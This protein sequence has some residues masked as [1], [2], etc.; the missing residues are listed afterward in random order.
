MIHV[1]HSE[2]HSFRLSLGS[3]SQRSV[4]SW[5]RGPLGLG[6]SEQKLQVDV[7]HPQ[8]EKHGATPHP[9]GLAGRALDQRG[10]LLRLISSRV[11]LSGPV[12]FALSSFRVAWEHHLFLLPYFSLLDYKCLSYACL[13]IVFWKPVTSPLT[14]S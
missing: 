4:C 13:T 14:G 1:S 10:L 5:E 2:Y 12:K 6:K 7:R 8:R 9:V 11:I 3:E